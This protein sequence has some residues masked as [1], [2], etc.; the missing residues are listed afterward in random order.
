MWGKGALCGSGV[1]YGVDHLDSLIAAGKWLIGTVFSQSDGKAKADK[2]P[3]NRLRSID[4]K[5]WLPQI[6]NV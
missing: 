5:G 4:D 3:R 1:H 6:L 2:T